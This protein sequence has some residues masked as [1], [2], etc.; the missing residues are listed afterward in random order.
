MFFIPN[1]KFIYKILIPNRL[2]GRFLTIIIAPTIL[3]QLIATYIFYQRHWNNVSGYMIANL[4]NEVALITDLYKNNSN[5]IS[6]IKKIA[7]ELNLK[8]SYD[9]SDF[10]K[11]PSDND[12]E[13]QTFYNKLCEQIKLPLN[14]NYNEKKSDIIIEIK[15]DS[16]KLSILASRRKIDTPTTYIF[17][18]WMIGTSTILSI[19]AILFLRNQIRSISKLA[20]AAEQFGKGQTTA[21][22]KPSG[23]YEV[24]KA[25]IAFLRMKERIERQ[26]TQRTQM[27]AAV[28]HDLR[29]PLTR[30]KL[31]LEMLSQNSE[32][33]DIKSDILEME[34]MIEHYLDFA[35][36]EGE[37]K[38]TFTNLNALI[39]TVI[40]SYRNSNFTFTF[41]THGTHILSVKSNALKRVLSNIIDNSMK[42]AKD[43][44]TINLKKHDDSIFIEIADNGPGVSEEEKPLVF[45]P[46]YRTDT[47]RSNAS[48]G[49]GLGLAI[50]KDIV[51]SHG[52]DITLKD[53]IPHGL[54]VIITLPV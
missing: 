7:H 29:T 43:E 32:I 26:I 48:G 53:N 44:I 19:F 46:F 28:S 21:L 4:S 38:P 27:L 23:A 18:L 54:K 9:N 47:A 49:V 17:I 8:I 20:S 39:Q 33:L 30:M 13:I 5:D 16:E 50:S 41:F 22:F 42:Y 45:R 24:K 52:G 12:E 1:L 11:I 3:A 36:G 6:L 31:E 35:R 15:L 10:I 14:I 2:F 51:N 34:K 40:A 25:G 37:E